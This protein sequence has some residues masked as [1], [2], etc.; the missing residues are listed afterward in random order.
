ML[1]PRMLPRLDGVNRAFWTGGADGRLMIQRCNACA[2]WFHPPVDECPACGGVVAP[3]PVSG[4]ATILTFTVDEQQFHP[5]VPPPYVI[6]VV[7]LEEQDDL[8]LATNIV[9]APP[10]SV[11]IGQR[12]RV[13]FEQHGEVFVP[14]FEPSA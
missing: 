2:K 9:N 3:E 1:A 8:R 6:A 12:V 4:N 11:A 14:V 7:V 13:V 5:E 10:G